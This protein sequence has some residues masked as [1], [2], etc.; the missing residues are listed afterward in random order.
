[1]PPGVR[2]FLKHPDKKSSIP[3]VAPTAKA[4]GPNDIAPEGAEERNMRKCCDTTLL[5]RY[6][7]REAADLAAGAAER[8]DSLGAARPACALFA[9]IRGFSRLTERVDLPQLRRFLGDFVGLFVEAVEE[10][11][12][13]V[14]KF[15]GDS[16]LALFADP[17]DAGRAAAAAFAVGT[18]FAAARARRAREDGAFADTDLGI[19]LACGEVFLGNIGA[20]A[21]YDFTAVGRAVNIAERLSGEGRGGILCDGAFAARLAGC[22]GAPAP[23]ASFAGR[24]RLRGMDLETDI[25]RLTPPT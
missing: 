15:M 23:A 10:A 20:G 16:G 17:P 24:V 4:T 2:N 12:G 5:A 22:P 13:M 19:G 6:L 3:H 25:F 1:M 9:D 11:G 8:P 18:A 14:N 7:G 21:R